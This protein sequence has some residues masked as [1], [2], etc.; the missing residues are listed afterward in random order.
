[1]ADET[2][3]VCT[4]TSAT[5]TQPTS[6]D[7]DNIFMSQAKISY[8]AVATPPAG[9]ESTP[10]EGDSYLV[11]NPYWTESS[12][13]LTRYDLQGYGRDKTKT[14][15][16]YTD[17]FFTWVFFVN[18]I[19][20]GQSANG[21]S[22]N[23]NISG[24]NYGSKNSISAKLKVNCKKTSQSQYCTKE[25]D[26]GSVY[27]RPST[28]ISWEE[29]MANPLTQPTPYDSEPYAE[30]GDWID[31]GD[32]VITLDAAEAEKITN[33]VYA[34]TRPGIFSSYDFSSGTIIESSNGLTSEKVSDW[35]SHCNKFAHWYNQND[36]DTAGTS[37]QATANGL[38]TA[39]WYNA[40]VDACADSTTRP[41]KVT[42][43]S[44]G[45]IITPSVFSNLGKAI[46]KDDS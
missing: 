38:I 22:G 45:T 15:D 8:A 32:P 31:Y 42:G 2:T 30:Y 21:P 6:S 29:V 9:G 39:G 17:L 44:T 11:G 18:N 16:S 41:A 20:T 12:D 7:R 1:M 33:T 35:I 14:V 23:A 28:E 4:I 5:L 36:T 3:P 27:T 43:G 46:S 40:C 24:L 13:G 26:E 25:W 37:C 10:V 19:Q 34:R